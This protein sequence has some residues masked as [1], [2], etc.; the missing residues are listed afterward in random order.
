M[1]F[2]FADNAS[3]AL[4]N[5]DNRPKTVCLSA[6]AEADKIIVEFADNGCG[7]P[8]HLLEDIFLDFVTT[9]GSSQNLGMG[10]SRARKIIKLHGGKI[11]AQSEGEGKGTYFRIELPKK[12]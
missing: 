2:I 10:L 3:Y 1:L 5:N 8:Q 4:Q 9:K 12:M 11:W 6:K 7:I